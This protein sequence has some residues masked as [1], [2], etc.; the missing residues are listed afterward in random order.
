MLIKAGLDLQ[1]D[2]VL[3]VYNN[4]GP[5]LVVGDRAVRFPGHGG[6][7][8]NGSFQFVEGEYMKPED[9]DAFLEDPADW[10]IRKLWPR[11]FTELEG[12][13]MLPPL[14][15]AAY[16]SYSLLNFGMLAI[17]PV[18]KAFHALG[19]AIEAQAA[20]DAR[21]VRTVQRLAA[22]GF[23][24]KLP[25]SLAPLWRPPSISCRTPCAGC[26][27]RRRTFTAGRRSSWPRKNRP[28]GFS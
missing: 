25:P 28:F 23:S 18:T 16:G 8:P 5:S 13:A 24:R 26:A 2:S 15:L 12:L 7:S 20:A 19:R 10:S 22:L 4:P 6:H 17:P 9:Y 21:A 14:G 11:I 1:S 3:G 27:A